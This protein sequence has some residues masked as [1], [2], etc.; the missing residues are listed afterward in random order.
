MLVAAVAGFA[1]VTIALWRAQ[2]GS[3]NDT[4]ASVAVLPFLS[5]SAA[6]NYLADGLSEATLNGLVQLQGL[7]VAPRASSLR[8]KGNAVSPKR[9]PREG[10]RRKIE[11]AGVAAP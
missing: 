11:L 10:L 4:F 9:G 2:P 8:Y 6:S 3:G 7:R 1:G 5:D